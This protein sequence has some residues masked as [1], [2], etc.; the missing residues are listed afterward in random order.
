MKPRCLAVCFLVMIGLLLVPLG[1]AQDKQSGCSDKATQDAPDS[2][3]EQCK[4]SLR[5]K[6]AWERD[7]EVMANAVN[8]SLILKHARY[9]ATDVTSEAPGG[10]GGLQ[11]L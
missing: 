8:Q 7:M 4:D 6:A 10:P 2:P 3:K 9:W 5:F 1:E 11:R